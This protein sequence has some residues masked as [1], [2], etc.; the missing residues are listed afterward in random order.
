[1]GK[2]SSR[3]VG[4]DRKARSD[5]LGFRLD[6]KTKALIQRAARLE[7]RKLTAYCLTALT[8]AAQRTVDQHER[9]QLSDRD[10]AVFFEVLVSPPPVSKRLERALVAERRRVER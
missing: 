5:R 4:S 1:M 3:T 7:R 2:T 8:D 9:L 6:P 10:R